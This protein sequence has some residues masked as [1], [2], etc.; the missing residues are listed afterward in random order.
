MNPMLLFEDTAN[1]LSSHDCDDIAAGRNPN[2]DHQGDQYGNPNC[3]NFITGRNSNPD[4][5]GD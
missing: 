1:T 2:P 5:Q 4:H 3:D